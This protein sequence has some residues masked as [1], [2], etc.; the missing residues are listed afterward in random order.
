MNKQL[1]IASGNELLRSSYNAELARAFADIRI[2][3]CVFNAKYRIN[4]SFHFQNIP[5]IRPAI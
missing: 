3:L 5:I 2:M 4:Y 1:V